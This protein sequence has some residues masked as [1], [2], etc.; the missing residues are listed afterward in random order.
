[1]PKAEELIYVDNL[2]QTFE[3]LLDYL[4]ET[5]KELLIALVI[6]RTA[7]PKNVLYDKYFAITGTLERMSRKEAMQIIADLGGHC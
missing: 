6:S 7:L 1:M 2:E 3:K 5:E 4:T